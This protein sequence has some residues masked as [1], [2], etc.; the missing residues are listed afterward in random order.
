MRIDSHRGEGSMTG[1][2]IVFLAAA[3]FSTKAILVKYSYRYGA[4]AL[5]TLALRM[6]FSIPFFI[7]M[8]VWGEM[9]SEKRIC[10]RDLAIIGA[11]GIVG[12]YL[13][14]YLD[15][16]GLMYVSAG[17]ERLILFMCPT[18]VVGISAIFMGRRIT[19]RDIFALALCYAGVFMAFA[20]EAG[21]DGE[22]VALGAALV[23]TATVTYAIYLVTGAEVIKRAGAMRFTAYAM[24]VSGMAV[25]T[26]FVMAKE[27]VAVR[28]SSEVAGLAIVMALIATV[29]PSL[30]MSEGLRRIGAGKTA[31][32]SS[33]G[34]VITI[35]L[36]YMTL[37]EP[38]SAPQI[39]GTALIIAGALSVGGDP[40]GGKA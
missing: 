32:V 9:R 7:A 2:L 20:N 39:G 25:M 19:A 29:I 15:F 4:D 16:L 31:I 10:G 5:T 26:H 3:G 18:I 37:G 12:Y 33:A 38:V 34:P 24:I 1:I 27:T 8:A 23:A 6:A 40:A 30:L 11:L 13:S 22:H 14:S 36:A 35:W 17:L 28:V 21:L